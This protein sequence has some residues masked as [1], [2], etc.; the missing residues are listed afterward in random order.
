M[1]FII[2]PYRFASVP[3]TSVTDTFNRADNAS[4][5]GN[6]DTGQM[7]VPNSGTWGISANR[8]YE[9]GVAG[10]QATTVVDSG[11]SDCYV[12]VTLT[13]FDD[14]G[15]CFRS[16]DDNNY[17]LTNGSTLFRKQGGVYGGIGGIGGILSGDVL[18]VELNGSSIKVYVNGSLALS[19]TDTFNQTATKHG[20]RKNGTD[21]AR[22]DDFS[23]VPL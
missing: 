16:T 22:F 6:A 15:L 4:S 8:A 12:E 3:A 2:D 7:W 11:M 14:T 13:T 21:V 17:F 19:V 23:V 5:M 9:T 20:L 18:K 1:S 10:V